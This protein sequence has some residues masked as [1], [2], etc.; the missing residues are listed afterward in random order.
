M[1]KI[2]CSLFVALSCAAIAAPML[3][4]PEKY[5]LHAAVQRSDAAEVER[6]LAT[7]DFNV[8][9]R[10]DDGLTALHY[11]A[12]AG[13]VDCVKK[14]LKHGAY[15]EAQFENIR[16]CEHIFRMLHE[17]DYDYDYWRV[18]TDEGERVWWLDEPSNATALHFAAGGGHLACVEYLVYE[19]GAN[20]KA[21]NNQGQTPKDLAVENG[22]QSVVDFFDSYQAPPE[23]KEPD[24]ENE[25]EKS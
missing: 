17:D 19:A 6:L 24:V 13:E 22:R 4:W 7:G 2:L 16:L 15:V 12:R 21:K 9:N 8:D 1:K 11:A 3:P 18:Y 5:P 23:I 20:I 14:L 10:C 25:N